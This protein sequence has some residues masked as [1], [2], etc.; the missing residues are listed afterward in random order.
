MINE[1]SFDWEWFLI[2]SSEN[3]LF[4]YDIDSQCTNLKVSNPPPA[5]LC[6]SRYKY[7]QVIWFMAGNVNYETVYINLC[8][9]ACVRV[10]VYVCVCVFECS[11][12][13]CLWLCV[14]MRM[15]VHMYTHVL[16][17]LHLHVCVW[18]A[19][20][21]TSPVSHSSGT[22]HLGFFEGLWLSWRVASRICWLAREPPT[23]CLSLPTTVIVF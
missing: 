13:I 12:C 10:G 5:L 11:M 1:S 19:H 23:I 15:C 18:S 21:T 16:M 17:C 3:C 8:I 6:L 2:F 14:N 7:N 20:N 9:C 22:I 4:L